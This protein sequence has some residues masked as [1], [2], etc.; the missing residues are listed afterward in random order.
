MVQTGLRAFHDAHLQVDGVAYDIHFHGVDVREDVTIVIIVVA[1]CVIVFFQALVDKFLVIDVTLL[2]IEHG[3]Q[4]VG[5]HDGV[6]HPC[7]ITDVVLVTLFNLYIDVHVLLVIVPD[8][9]FEDSGIAEAQFVV[10]LYQL[11]LGLLVT[12]VGELLGLEEV[13]ELTS[14][15]DLTEGAFGEHTTLDLRVLEFLVAHQIDV[16]HLH[17]VLLVDVHVEHHLPLVVRVVALHDVD[18]S[19]LIALLVEVL[20]GQ[21][22]GSVDHIRRD[23]AALDDAQ[24]GLHILA[25]RLLD[26]QIVDGAHPGAEGQRDAQVDLRPH[27][28]VGADLGLGEQTVTPI[29]L[30]G[31]RNLIAWHLH[32]LSDTQARQARQHVVFIALDTF[33]GDAADDATAGRASIRDVGIDDLILSSRSEK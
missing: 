25:L 15:M 12:L 26:A 5:G 14:L 11:L 2:H 19:V 28:G 10:F 3:I 17:L 23:L 24:L 6:A 33:H 21:D 32:L 13:S 31:F 20:L 18:L 7:D 29:A 22:L 1:G 8:G 9:V 16:A 30:H 4:V 27:D